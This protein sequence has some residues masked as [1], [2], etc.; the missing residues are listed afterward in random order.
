MST[1]TKHQEKTYGPRYF[2]EHGQQ[3]RI[4][5]MVR[6]DDRCGNGHNTFSI[7]CD[8]DRKG[9]GPSGAWLESSGGCCHDEVAKHF[10]ELAPLIKWHGTSTDG[11]L[12]YVANTVHLA[13]DRDCWGGRKGE[14]QWIKFYVRPPGGHGLLVEWPEE[15]RRILGPKVQEFDARDEAEGAASA[16]GGEVVEWVTRFHE[17]KDRELDAA[18]RAAIWPEAT[19]EQLTA[20]GLKERLEVRLPALLADFRAAVESLGL[21]Y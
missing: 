12:H 3:F 18:R 20:P 21:T 7:T 8:I 1:L 2:T 11:P 14:P 17:G 4:T 5:V 6:H 9:R 13:S 16:C 15:D 10:P 19:D